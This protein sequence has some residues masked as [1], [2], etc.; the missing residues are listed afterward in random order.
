MPLSWIWCADVVS[1]RFIL[2]EALVVVR[3]LA[4]TDRAA[5]A[6]FSD[7]RLFGPGCPLALPNV[8]S[9]FA[10]PPFWMAP[11]LSKNGRRN[12]LDANFENDVFCQE[13]KISEFW[14]VIQ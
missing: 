2:S 4:L 1:S 13:R 14:V 10:L 3:D 9:P 8:G 11:V 12:Y 6:L 7:M 5:C